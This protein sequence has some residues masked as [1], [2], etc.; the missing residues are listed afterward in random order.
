[1]KNNNLQNN[2]KI[3]SSQDWLALAFVGLF[4]GSVCSDIVTDGSL[5]PAGPLN[6]PDFQITA[7]LGKQAGN[8]LFHSFKT[9]DLFNGERAT[10]SGPANV[11][12]IFSRVTGGNFTTINGWLRST[13]PGQI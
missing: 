12:N 5:G 7:S 2:K 6:G 11:E 10:F 4:S 1:M 13:I 8:N 3:S 9:F